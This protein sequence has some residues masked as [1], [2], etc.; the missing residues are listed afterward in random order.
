MEFKEIESMV[1]GA[2]ISEDAKTLILDL[3]RILYANPSIT[4]SIVDTLNKDDDLR[5]RFLAMATDNH[6]RNMVQQ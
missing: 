6:K 2:A 4:K 5:A 1:N 3:A